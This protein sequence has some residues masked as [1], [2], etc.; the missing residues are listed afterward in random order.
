MVNW[1][2][3]YRDVWTKMMH[4]WLGYCIYVIKCSLT[5]YA[6]WLG[7]RQVYACFE[8]K[9]VNRARFKLSAKMLVLGENI[10]VGLC[11]KF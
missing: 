6:V 5:I 7:Y 2:Q 3:I 11:S 8:G 9:L 4:F 10:G 1:L